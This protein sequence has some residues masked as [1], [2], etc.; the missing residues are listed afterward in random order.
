M[1]TKVMFQW[2]SLEHRSHSGLIPFLKLHHNVAK[3]IVSHAC[4]NYFLLH[5]W[6]RINEITGNNTV[7]HVNLKM[8]EQCPMKQIVF[9]CIVPLFRKELIGHCSPNVNAL[10]LQVVLYQVCQWLYC[11]N[12][13]CTWANFKRMFSNC[14]TL[15]LDPNYFDLIVKIYVFKAVWMIKFYH[16]FI[17][18]IFNS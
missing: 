18:T 5:M 3:I 16:L 6:A 2:N 9:A 1:S 11:H 14:M 17:K 8:I 15:L 4:L 12:S 13:G 7:K 10:Q